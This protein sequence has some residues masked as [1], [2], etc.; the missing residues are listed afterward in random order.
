M[1]KHEA[2][3]QA[4]WLKSCME[5]KSNRRI[6]LW[7]VIAVLFLIALFLVVKVASLPGSVSAASSASS[8]AQSAYSMV[9]SC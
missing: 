8:S 4:K 2:E 7:V 6:V 1:H 5:K 3:N 9:G